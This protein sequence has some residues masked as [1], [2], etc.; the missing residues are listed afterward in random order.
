MQADKPQ[1][2]LSADQTEDMIHVQVRRR[3]VLCRC[4]RVHSRP[5]PPT[6]SV[7]SF[8]ARPRCLSSEELV[9]ALDDKRGP[10]FFRLENQNFALKI[11]NNGDRADRAG[12]SDKQTAQSL[13]ASSIF[14][15][16]SFTK[17]T[18]KFLTALLRAKMI[19]EFPS[20]RRPS[21]AG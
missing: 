11:F 8:N 17:Q 14:L 3:R 6:S 19:A 4:A 7:A 5:A 15:E 1:A 13:Y 21:L 9:E 10:S 16:A 12:R 20:S 2:L 18:K